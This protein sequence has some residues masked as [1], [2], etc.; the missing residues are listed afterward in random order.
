MKDKKI[1]DK[2]SEAE[3]NVQPEGVE[4]DDVNVAEEEMAG[5]DRYDHINSR[6]KATGGVVENENA[7]MEILKEVGRR[8]W[9]GGGGCTVHSAMYNLTQK[10]VLW[11]ANE[12]FGDKTA[13]YSYSL[14]T[15]ELKQVG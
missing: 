7:A 12:N 2:T 5:L 15:G 6:L 1:Y 11:V 9:N 3:E 14:A 8:T 4:V 13:T 10:T